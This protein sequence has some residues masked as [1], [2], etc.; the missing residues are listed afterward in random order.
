MTRKRENGAGSIINLG[1]N[2]TR[3]FRV[4]ITVGYDDNGKQIFQNLGYFKTRREA[5]LQLALFLKDK[6]AWLS[7]N[8]TMEQLYK[9]FTKWK[10]PDGNIPYTYSKPYERLS[11]FH[12]VQFS[13]IKALHIQPIIDTLTRPPAQQIKTLFNQLSE[14]ALENDICQKN[15][16]P[17]IRLPE[18][19]PKDIHR[20]LSNEE[21]KK[22]CTNLEI[23]GVEFIVSMIY[24]GCRL[25][26]LMSLTKDMV[27]LDERYVICGSK[28]DA[29]KNRTIPLHSFIFPIIERR[30]NSCKKYIFE[31]DGKKPSLSTMRRVL[32][33]AQ[34]TLG[35]ER[36][37]SHSFRHTFATKLGE[38]GV[39][40][41]TIRK[42]LGHS[43]DSNDT[44]NRV[45]FHRSLEILKKAVDTLPD[46]CKT[47][48]K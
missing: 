4:R 22:L 39:A 35:I 28:T 27:H 13:T 33:E 14:F 44:L 15:Y 48:I 9:Q 1:G 16:A 43:F 2:R 26:E 17:Y 41:N 38:L 30:Y 23:A 24:T 12:K 42:L 19:Q 40:E 5:E 10:Y 36:T 25:N 37:T 6:Q 7:G 45:Y 20:C 31:D 47:Q 32:D 46:Y 3:P 11:Q 18:A 29:G 34:D 8:V 21:L